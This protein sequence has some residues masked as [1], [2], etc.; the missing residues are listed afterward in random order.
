VKTLIG[1]IDMDDPYEN[2]HAKE[3]QF[4]E[5]LHE[6]IRKQLDGNRYEFNP[7]ADYEGLGYTI[8]GTMF[9]MNNSSVNTYNIRYQGKDVKKVTIPPFTTKTPKKIAKKIADSIV[10]E[11]QKLE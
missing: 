3:P 8:S 6:Q 11:I 2:I 10:K 5:I 9:W 7:E 4:N 1:K